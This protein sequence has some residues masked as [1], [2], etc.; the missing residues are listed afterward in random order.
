MWF[1]AVFDVVGNLFGIGRDY[2]E[3]K[4]N[5]EKAKIETRLAIEEA[6]AKS[7]IKVIETGQ[8]A[9]IDWDVAA[10]EGSANSWKDEW[11][12][13]LFSIPLILSFTPGGAE[14]VRDG[15]DVLTGTPEWYQISVGVIV[16]ASFGYRKVVDAFKKAKK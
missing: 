1:T 14:I 15:F 8:I 2:L 9:E 13:V 6:K 12:T 4:R 7:A 11:L 16:A 10:M 5:I 3:G